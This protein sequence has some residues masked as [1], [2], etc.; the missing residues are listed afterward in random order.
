MI[1]VA[2]VLDRLTTGTYTFTRTAART[3]TLGRLAAAS[4]S[5]FT[6]AAVVLQVPPR[7][8]AV[9]PEGGTFQGSRYLW[10]RTLLRVNPEPDTVVIGGET[11]EVRQV[12][13]RSDHGVF[14]K[15]LVVLV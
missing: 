10:T 7:D 13:D 1:D 8:Y 12:W 5:T 3:D 2:A 15:A 6:A 9:L 14:Y 11:W 4:T